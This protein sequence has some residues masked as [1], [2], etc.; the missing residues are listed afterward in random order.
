MLYYGSLI[1]HEMQKSNVYIMWNLINVYSYDKSEIYV[2]Y[3]GILY[4]IHTIHI[5]MCIY[6]HIYT[7]TMFACRHIYIQ[8][9]AE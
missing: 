6:M 1:F 7:Y 5:C 3:N 9:Y 2:I 8:G 4:V